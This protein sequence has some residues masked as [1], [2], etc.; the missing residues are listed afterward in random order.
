MKKKKTILTC[1]LSAVALSTVQAQELYDI[2]EYYIRNHD[3]TANV[4]YD[5]DSAEGN[6]KNGTLLVPREWTL[7][8]GAK[9]ALAVAATFRYGTKATFGDKSIP[10]AG[11]DGTAN[12]A[13]LTLSASYG[14][15]MAFCQKAKMPAG[16]YKMLVTYYNCN[17]DAESAVA[18]MSGWYVSKDDNTLSQTLTF[19]TAEWRTDTIAF[20][21]DEVSSG[22]LQI[23]IK[24]TGAATKNAMLAVDN[25]RL[26]RDTP[27]GP[28]DDLLPAP[29]VVTDPRFARGA[30]MAFGRIKTTTGEDISERG[31]CWAETPDPTINDNT[32]TEFLQNNGNIYW[33]K[34]L[35]PATLYYMRAYAKNSYGKVGYGE[36]IKFY[37]IPKGQIRLNMRDGGDQATYDRIKKA[38]E[39][40]VDWWNN[41]TEMKD[42]SPSV[43]F[44]DGT[45]TADCSYGGWI[46]VGANQ[47]YQ[48]TGTIMHEMLHGCGVIPWADT[49]WSRF[50]LRAGTSNAAGF[51]TGSGQWLGDRVTEVLRF[52]DN[53][54][55]AVLNGDYQHL[56]PYGING[57]SEDNGSDVLYIGNSLVC[58]AL[59]EDGLQHTTTHFA[60]PYY[61]FS[62]E[63]DTKYY[64]KCEDE[65]RGLYTSYLMPTKTGT[66]QWVAMTAND[67][68]QNDTAAWYI[69]FTPSNQYYQLRNAATGQYLTY[70]GA[71]KTAARTAPAAAD[72][73]HFMRGR[74]DVAS[75]QEGN[76]RGF[77]IIHPTANWTPP[78]LQ[79]NADKAVGSATFDISNAATSQRWLILTA[80]EA[81]QMEQTAV[82]A[83]K[84]V[85]KASLA[86]I[87]KLALVPHKE[88][89]PGTDETYAAS[90]GDI[91]KR[92]EEATQLADVMAL[93]EEAAQAAF[94]FLCNVS[95]T[96]RSQP[97]DLTYM[98]QSPGMDTTDGWTGSPTLNYSC[99]EFYQTTFNFYQDVD[100]LPGGDYQLL[101]QG[102]QRPGDQAAAYTDYAAGKDNVNATLYAGNV[103]NATK[104]AHIASAAQ[105]KKA[106]KGS[107]ATVGGSLY[108]PDNMQAA[109]AYFDKGLYENSVDATVDKDGSTLR[110]GIRST[111]Q[112]SK[113]WTIFDNF[114][115]HFFGKEVTT[116][117]GDVNGDGTVDVADIATIISVMAADSDASKDAADVNGDGTTD[118]ADIATVISI[119]AGE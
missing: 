97:F 60:E 3:F 62:Q 10:T 7:S 56:W 108:V 34:E 99:A 14:N 101:A 26:L 95:A 36:T 82:V 74:I 66:L 106:G 35:K 72:N 104:L 111:T 116:I 81:A 15:F 109:A 93:E 29:V 64:L 103:S 20:S 84:D 22:L 71:F 49:E 107:E 88:L 73:F 19:G 5:L 9:G 32:T 77:W 76:K 2:T 80:E 24:C 75:A 113:Y 45:P 42:F 90:L 105:T 110:I 61:A 85:V 28:Q 18:N 79:A 53:S 23:G 58:Q 63:D 114:R 46:R 96:D 4:D 40:A 37:T 57:A 31:F 30:T 100:N 78:C 115:L 70:S 54:T 59:G 16:N 68:Q 1:L 6:V 41:L 65:E 94:Q 86:N 52:W 119:M 17:D 92:A 25:V 98:V 47:S 13:C 39:T 8:N 11:P 43:G 87:R 117:K 112:P 102:F 51:T 12:G 91:E 44:V 67:A 55:T 27:Y 83:M 50:N 48:R 118:V 21:L 69:T 33:L 89:A 38:A